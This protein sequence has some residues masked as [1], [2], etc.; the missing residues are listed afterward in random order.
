VLSVQSIMGATQIAHRPRSAIGAGWGAFS[1]S[2]WGT[3][4]PSNTCDY[5]ARCPTIA[6]FGPWGTRK[7]ATI[8][9]RGGSW[10]AIV[11]RKGDARRTATFPTKGMAQAW[12]ER[13]EREIAARRAT[14]ASSADSMTLRQVLEWYVEHAGK[15]AEFGRSKAS[16]LNR[17]KT[18]AIADRIASGLRMQDYVRHAEDRRRDG[19]GPATTLND[20][21][22]LRQAI[23]AAR[24]SLGLNASLSA[25]QDATEHLRSSRTIAKSKVRKRRLL[26]GEEAKLAAYFAAR[27]SA[28]P[29]ADI[30]A[31][32]LSSARRQEEITRIRWTDVDAGKG[33]AWLDDVKHPRHK[34]GNRKAFRLL[35]EALAIVER[36]PRTADTV[37]PYNPKT[38]GALFTRA[39]GMLGLEDLHFH[40]LRHEATSRLFERGYAIHEVAQFTLHESWATLK[41]YT[42]LRPEDVPLKG[43]K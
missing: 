32:A 11:R 23:K 3:L 43:D 7:V 10:R 4:L 19:A 35:P 9:K 6:P 36:Q 30:I 24:A 2:P 42:N 34:E 41:R 31:F 38:I 37:F 26:P 27:A 22:W 17:L 39:V 14:G 20:L 12:I 15:L 28:V 1:R 33:I 21:V 29:M 13:T 8:E 18:C 5:R 25:L 16:D 40:D